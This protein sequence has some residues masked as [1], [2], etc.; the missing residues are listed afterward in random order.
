M[1]VRFLESIAGVEFA[2]AKNQEADLP[3]DTAIQ[4][5]KEGLAEPI[6]EPE[7]KRASKAADKAAENAEKR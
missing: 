5:I 1:K 2:Y 4:F 3:S 6:G 7:H